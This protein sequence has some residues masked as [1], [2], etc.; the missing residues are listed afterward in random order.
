MFEE[1]EY[2]KWKKD[3]RKLSFAEITDMIRRGVPIPGIRDIPDVVL[4]MPVSDDVILSPR[5]PWE[6]V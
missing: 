1:L 5:K 3:D 4:E 2:A 6:V